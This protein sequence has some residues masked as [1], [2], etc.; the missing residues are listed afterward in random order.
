M[1]IRQFTQTR[2]GPDDFG[3]NN[4]HPVRSNAPAG[5]WQAGALDMK[6]PMIDPT[7]EFFDLENG[8]IEMRTLPKTPQFSSQLKSMRAR[9]DVRLDH[10]KSEVV[11]Q[12]QYGVI[13]D[14]TFLMSE[15]PKKQKR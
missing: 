5:L 2:D 10:L 8:L 3:H 4:M 12:K 6:Y 9:Y 13:F 1:L 7:E 11:H 14:R 15:K